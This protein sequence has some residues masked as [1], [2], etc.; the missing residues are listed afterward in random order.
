MLRISLGRGQEHL[1]ELRAPFGPQIRRDASCG[2]LVKIR[3]MAAG[4][5]KGGA[6]PICFTC[7]QKAREGPG[8]IRSLTG[9]L[10]LSWATIY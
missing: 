3:A 6:D 8:L 7:G 5:D 4:P 10:A 2:V 1:R 9:T